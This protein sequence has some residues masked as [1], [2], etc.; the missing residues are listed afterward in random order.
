M[1]VRFCLKTQTSAVCLGMTVLFNISCAR[2]VN[3]PFIVPIAECS[4]R[5]GKGLPHRIQG[6]L[7]HLSLVTNCKPG[8]EDQQKLTI[9]KK[10]R[11]SKQNQDIEKNLSTA[12]LLCLRPI[13]SACICTQLS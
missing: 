4:D 12:A 2:P 1:R 5:D 3:L 10:H 13:L 6:I 8:A 9:L 11:A 7:H